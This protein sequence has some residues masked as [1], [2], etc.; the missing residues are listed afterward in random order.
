[1][2]RHEQNTIFMRPGWAAAAAIRCAS[3]ASREETGRDPGDEGHDEQPD[4][5][6]REIAPD[7]PQAGSG[8][9]LADRACGVVTEPE[10]RCEQADAHGEDEADSIMNLVHAQLL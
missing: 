3:R 5:Q 4:N 7:A 6:R 8:V 2:S 9:D 1:M 10:G